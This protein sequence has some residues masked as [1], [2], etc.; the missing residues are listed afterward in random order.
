[1]ALDQKGRAMTPKHKQLAGSAPASHHID[2]R[3]HQI[4]A[5][6]EGEA[7]DLLSTKQVADWLCV[8]IQWLEIGR[9]NDEDGAQKY[10]PPFIRL[11]TR[12][13]RYKRA[14]VTAWLKKRTH[15]RTAEYGC[16][17]TPAA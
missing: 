1:M 14:D 16:R 11:S 17:T 8:S 2:K 9:M 3:A 4:I 15:A 12:M 10:G 13:I 5:L 6:S 7:D